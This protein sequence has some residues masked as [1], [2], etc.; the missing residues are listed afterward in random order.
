MTT[1]I[2]TLNAALARCPLVA[3]LRGVRPDEVEA[4]GDAIIEAGFS[5][6][7][8]PLNSPDP[9]AS[10]ALLAKRYGPD[11]LV[12]AGTVLTVQNVA[13]VKAAG[14][15]LIIS[16]NVNGDVIRA[17][18]AAGM[19]SL[20]GFYTPTEAFSALDAGATGLKLFPAEGASPAYMKAQRAVLPK[21]LPLLAVGG[22]T[23]ENLSQWTAAGAQGAG[24]GSA[25]YKAGLS[26]AEVGARAR[27]F[28]A[29]VAALP[30]SG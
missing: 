3:I 8:V 16:P 4:I 17:T 9:L 20:P 26:A 14:G 21:D 6:I 28:I 23:P 27:A 12:G 25:L 30:K 22:V 24:L 29:A 10:I 7:E 2:E 5:M 15:R 13:D 19:I 11:V 1:P 18:V